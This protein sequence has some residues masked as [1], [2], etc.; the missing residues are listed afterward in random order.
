MLKPVGLALL[1]VFVWCVVLTGGALFGWWK[2]AIAP[3]DDAQAFVQ[4]AIRLIDAG[5][6]GNTA[7]VLIEHGV[8]S[9]EYYS[10][11]ADPID[12]D[13]VFATAS[14]SKWITAL[15][16]MKLVQQ[17]K[18]DLDRPVEDYLTRWRLPESAFSSRDVTTRRLLSHRAGLVDGL[19]FGD[20]RLDETLPT[21]EQS[22]S[23]P[24]TSDGRPAATIRVGV[25]P[26]SE[27]RYSGG[28]YLLLELLVEEISGVRFE[29][30]VQR[31][32]FEPLGMQRSGYGDL[33]S[34]TRSAKS[35]YPDGQPAPIYHYASKA[36]TGLGTSANDLAILARATLGSIEDGPLTMETVAS[37]RVA[38]ASSMGVGIWGLGTILYA[39]TDDGDMVF[40]HDGVNEPAISAT[41]RINPDTAD[42]IVVLATGSKTLASQ[43]GGEWVFWQTGLP[44]TLSIPAEIRRVMPWL[45]GG[46]SGIV[47]V[48]TIVV[49]RSRRRSADSRRQS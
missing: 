3:A 2:Q 48:T 13:T 11:V 42:A 44:D 1:A 43:L 7:V 6:R 39:P 37:M 14:L 15:A 21:L 4:A 46:V 34:I 28:G 49:W 19:G 12:R 22:L 32:I 20:Y 30:F 35:Y 27:F 23:N 9:T 17:G 40:G 38:E 24:R 31:E 18:L 45:I 8:V 36:A 41:V 33:A 25:E 47:L 10:T 26:G 5:N 16:V 29:A